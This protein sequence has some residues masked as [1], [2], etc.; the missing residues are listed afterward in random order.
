MNRECY[1]IGNDCKICY[2]E[3]FIET[4]DG[5]VN[6]RIIS[7]IQCYYRDDRERQ[8]PPRLPDRLPPKIV[9]RPSSPRYNLET[10]PRNNPD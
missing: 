1:N 4:P 5:S 3:R 7:D 6:H 10:Y 8:A 2:T 9:Y